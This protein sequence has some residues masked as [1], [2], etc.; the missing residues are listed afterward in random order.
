MESHSQDTPPAAAE[1]RGGLHQAVLDA[2]PDMACMFDRGH[3]CAYA[4][5]ALLEACRRRPEEVIG[6]PLAELD[7]ALVRASR[8]AAEIDQVFASGRPLRGDVTFHDQRGPR[9]HDYILSPVAA[10]DGSVEA[11]LATLRDV[12]ERT[13]HEDV[14]RRNERRLRAIA[15]AS[16][17]VI[18]RMDPDWAGVQ[19]LVGRGSDSP[20]PLSRAELLQAHLHPEDRERIALV[21]SR[22]REEATVFEAEYRWLHGDGRYHWLASRVVPVRGDDGRVQEWVGATTDVDSR[23]QQEQHQKLL[24]DELNHRV[25]NTLAVVQSIALQTLG[26][27]EAG[28]A[29]VEHFQARLLA[30]AK[31]HELLTASRWAGTCLRDVVEMAIG[32][33]LGHGLER[34][35]VDGP[36]VRLC[37]RPSL[38]LSMALHELYTNAVKYGA[39]SAPEGR[40]QIHWRVRDG[41]DGRRLLLQWRESDGPPV[42]APTR[43]G[44]GTRLVEHGLRHDL[45]GRVELAFERG[46]VTC[47]IDVPLVED[48]P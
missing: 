10:T 32:P 16:S 4:N 15:S 34:F 31:A 47:N 21:S 41:T 45:D 19:V 6:R 11:V 12:T 35:S 25:K 44:F 28:R 46:G 48:G 26:Q 43:R 24:L 2:M 37:P 27:S 22:A 1:R 33:G 39:L 30:L 9:I 38:A 3:R 14:A 36:P 7:C 18:Y 42:V 29:G 17:G 8:H 13:R 20:A 40:I 23:R 5:R